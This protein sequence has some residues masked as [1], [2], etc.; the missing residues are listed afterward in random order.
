MN[1]VIRFNICKFSSNQTLQTLSKVDKKF[2]TIIN[3]NFLWFERYKLK[4]TYFVPGDILCLSTDVPMCLIDSWS[5]IQLCRELTHG[6]EYN[7]HLELIRRHLKYIKSLSKSHD[8]AK[9]M[10]EWFTSLFP[11]KEVF[12]YVFKSIN[13]FVNMKYPPFLI[14]YGKKKEQIQKF[15]EFVK[16][17]LD[18]NERLIKIFKDRISSSKIKSLSDHNF[19]RGRICRVFGVATSTN[20]FKFESKPSVVRRIKVIPVNECQMKL[21]KHHL[22]S[23]RIWF[24]LFLSQYAPNDK[25]AIPTNINNLTQDYISG[26]RNF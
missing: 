20:N 17:T 19:I 13:Q 2:W 4:F 16:L 25:L 9:Q 22:L 24:L 7:D 8:V 12:K 10:I 15:L 21:D 3:G 14:F 11:D 26:K 1:N 5:N 23:F 6:R 18:S